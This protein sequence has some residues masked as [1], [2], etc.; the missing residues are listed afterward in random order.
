LL[1]NNFRSFLKRSCLTIDE[2]V[3]KTWTKYPEII[4]Q[5]QVLSDTESSVRIYNGLALRFGMAARRNLIANEG[6]LIVDGLFSVGQD[7]VSY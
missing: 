3:L 2:K 7:T 4:A 6:N 5:L 1:E